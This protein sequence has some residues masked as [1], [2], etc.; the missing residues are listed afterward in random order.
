MRV[1]LVILIAS[2]CFAAETHLRDSTHSATVKVGEK[3]GPVHTVDSVA[4]VIEKDGILYVG[5][6]GR[7]TY[8]YIMSN[9]TRFEIRK[10]GCCERNSNEH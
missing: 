7:D 3:Y 8:R 2:A 1:A 4:Y 9:T 10:G 6:A 5:R